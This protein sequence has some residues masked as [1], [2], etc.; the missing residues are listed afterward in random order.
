MFLVARNLGC[1][2]T[3][4]DKTEDEYLL[5]MKFFDKQGMSPCK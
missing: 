2:Q 1:V 5:P 3:A 4:E